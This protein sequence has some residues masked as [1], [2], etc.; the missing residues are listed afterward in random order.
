[1]K[2]KQDKAKNKKKKLSKFV[3]GISK[4]REFFSENL[5]ALISSGLPI[6]EALRSIAVDL[7][8]KQIKEIVL[9]VSDLVEG[10]GS[11]WESLRETGIF[12]EN[13]ISLIR[14]GEETGRLSDNLKVVAVQEQKTR[15]LTSKIR[16]AMMYPVFVMSIAAFAAIMIAWFILPRLS[17][18]FSQ[19]D[20]ELPIVTRWLIKV[21][22]FLGEYGLIAV[23]SIIG[24]VFIGLFLVF[25]Y[26]KTKFI[27]QFILFKTPGISRLIK[28]IEIARLG[29]LF[30]TL[31]E[32]GIPIVESI[33]SL[34]KAT[35]FRV[36]RD[37]YS[38]LGEQITQGQSI[39]GSFT[40]YKKVNKIIPTPVQHMMTSAERSGNL[41]ETL[42]KIG[43]LY[44]AK[45]DDTTKNL[46]TILEPILLVIVWLGVVAV[47]LAVILPIYSLI[48]GFNSG[49]NSSTSKQTTSAPQVGVVEVAA[50][51]PELQVIATSTEDI[52]FEDLDLELVSEIII[53]EE[54]VYEYID[55]VDGWY[56]ILLPGDES[57]W[58]HQDNVKL[59]GEKNDDI[60]TED[61]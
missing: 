49:T 19:L 32:A 4:D 1:M 51:F 58:I 8:T 52:L 50:V 37:L 31:L 35:T 11:L 61:Q 45:T 30:G 53:D 9:Y 26:S 13:I 7:R 2:R 42:K 34:K 10:G 48:G 23:P 15:I 28:D 36:Y 24:V 47:A 54:G 44:E 56:E 39:Q 60:I 27:G 18:V 6:T 41:P 16:S 20:I 33:D 12:K 22:E 25:I 46:T 55:E 14:I 57:G 21:G 3:F 59:S 40:A 43:E 29:F 38:F 17:T 5:S